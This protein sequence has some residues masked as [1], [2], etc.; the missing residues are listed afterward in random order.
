MLIK[1]LEITVQITPIYDGKIK[2]PYYSSKVV[3]AK[4][5]VYGENGEFFWTVFGK[6]LNIETEPYKRD[7]EIRGEGPYKYLN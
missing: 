4:F 2:S 3:D 1:Y 6:R 7:V 5:T